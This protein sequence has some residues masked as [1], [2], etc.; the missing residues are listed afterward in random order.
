ME[1]I[2][3][4]SMEC[5]GEFVSKPATWGLIHEGLD[6]SN[7][8]AEV[9]KPNRIVR[10]QGDIVEV[11]GFAEGIITAAMGIAGPLIQSLQLAEMTL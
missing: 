8:C 9:G 2:L 5:I 11:D 1:G 6:G 3:D 10:P 7:Q 4:L